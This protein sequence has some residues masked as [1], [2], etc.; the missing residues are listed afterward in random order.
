MSDLGSFEPW[1]SRRARMREASP[2]ARAL[3]WGVELLIVKSA[4]DVR[5]EV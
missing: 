2:Y 1:P 3:G 5:Q 4:D